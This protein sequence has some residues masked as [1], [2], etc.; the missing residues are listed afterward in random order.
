LSRAALLALLVAACDSVPG[1]ERARIWSAE[2]LAAAARTGESV[3]GIDARTLVAP[4]GAAIPW[5]SPPHTSTPAVQPAG[6]DGLVV[7]PA[8]LDGGRRGV[9]R[10]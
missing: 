1:S 5:L 10:R 9:W 3:A 8:W 6:T 7:V 2:D 4:G